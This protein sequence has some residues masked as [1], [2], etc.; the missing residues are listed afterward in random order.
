MFHFVFGCPCFNCLESVCRFVQ[1]CITYQTEV[2]LANDLVYYHWYPSYQINLNYLD[3]GFPEFKGHGPKLLLVSILE[4]VWF[5][6][7]ALFFICCLHAWKLT[8][9]KNHPK[10]LNKKLKSRKKIPLATHPNLHDFGFKILLVDLVLLLLFFPSLP[11]TN[12]HFAPW[13]IGRNP[14]PFFRGEIVRFK[15]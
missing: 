4:V 1:C 15:Y 6:I 5:V 7:L 3:T 9:M 2:S 14:I 8:A 12:R 13:R 11:E 10:I